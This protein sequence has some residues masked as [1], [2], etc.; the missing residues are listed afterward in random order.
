MLTFLRASIR[1]RLKASSCCFWASF[2][3]F[4]FLLWKPVT[5]SLPTKQ[6]TP[7]NSLITRIQRFPDW[8]SSKVRIF[9]VLEIFLVKRDGE[10]F[11]LASSLPNV[12]STSRRSQWT[13]LLI[14]QAF[15]HRQI[16]PPIGNEAVQVKN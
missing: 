8:I 16:L 1:F 6:H 12:P 2:L 5:K 11:V 7:E 14:M 3:L 13:R 9:I 15:R 4:F 10:A